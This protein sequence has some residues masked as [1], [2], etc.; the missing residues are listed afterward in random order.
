M[1]DDIISDELDSEYEITEEQINQFRKDG[2]IKLKNVLSP[3]LLASFEDIVTKLVIKYDY[4]TKPLQDRSTYDQA[5]IQIM[6]IWRKD[7]YVKKYVFCKRFS[8]IARR[9]MGTSGIRIYHDQ[10]LYKEPKG[11]FTPWHCDQQYWPVS[12][13]KIC[14]IWIPFQETPDEMGPLCFAK[15]SQEYTEG[16]DLAISD[17]SEEFLSKKMAEQGYEINRAPFELGEV[18]FHSGWTFHFAPLNQTDKMRKVMTMIYMDSEMK[19]KE[20]ETPGQ[21][22]DKETWCPGVEVG[23]VID[24]P[25][26]PKIL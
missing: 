15:G 25:I 18:S 5:F 3:K 8:G 21:E 2:F 10:A 12:S 14:T 24:C 1:E 9:L 17:Q 4:R 26:T 22:L 23:E 16:R 20:P 6:N 19:L 13:N 7:E 11:G